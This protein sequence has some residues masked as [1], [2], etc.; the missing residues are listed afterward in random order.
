MNIPLFY[1]RITPTPKGIK[2]GRDFWEELAQQ[3]QDESALTTTK[4][5]S[6]FY[7]HFSLKFFLK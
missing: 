6:F 7:S 3:N 1:M 4:S 5:E 2:G